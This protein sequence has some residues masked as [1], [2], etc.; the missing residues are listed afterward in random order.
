MNRTLE[1]TARAIFKSWFVDFDPVRGTAAI[2]DEIRCLFPDGLVD[3]PIGPIP[4]GW[5][6]APL[7]EQV[8]VTRGLSYTGDELGDEGMPL[9]NLNSVLEGGGYKYDGIKYYTGEY[10][11]RDLVRPGD[12]IVAATEQGFEHLLIGYPAVVP[13]LFGDE[14]LYS[15]DLSRVRPA[16]GSP[17]TSRFIYL[18]FV[19][20]RM[21]HTIA[22]YSNGTTV[23]HLAPEGL[24]KP[25]IAVPPSEL[26]ASFDEVVGPMFDQQESLVAESQTLGDLRDALLPKLISGE[27]RLDN[28]PT[29]PSDVDDE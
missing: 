12:V 4:E 15:Q 14:G 16:K 8:E 5:A 20:F 28:L 18:L 25:L 17:F 1:E 26:V 21:H 24:C 22:G 11:E 9:H 3:S 7:G 13:R 2:R 19:G 23:N 6:V 27:F 10:R 29:S